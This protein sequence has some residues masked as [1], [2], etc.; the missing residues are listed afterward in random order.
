MAYLALI[1]IRTIKIQEMKS[2]MKTIFFDEELVT[3]IKEEKI[4]KHQLYNYLIA[5]RITLK[6]YLKAVKS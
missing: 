5:G 4:N 2:I 6:E 3:T 1:F